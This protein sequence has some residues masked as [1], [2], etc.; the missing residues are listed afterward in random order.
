MKM[1]EGALESPFQVG[2][3]VPRVLYS[4][5]PFKNAFRNTKYPLF[6]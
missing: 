5:Q 1:I 2:F 6:Y 4:V 3:Y